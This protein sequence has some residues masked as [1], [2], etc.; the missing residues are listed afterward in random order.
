MDELT[1]ETAASTYF[2]YGELVI[3]LVYAQREEQSSI[4]PI[5]DLMI[6]ELYQH[7]R[8]RVMTYLKEVGVLG[9]SRNDLPVHLDLVL[10]T[11]LLVV[12]YV[13]AGEPRLALPVLQQ[14]EPYLLKNELQI[15]Y[16]F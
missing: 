2:K 3:T 12:G 13:P 10:F 15:T 14:D 11:L 5:H 1:H 6:P 4:P 9:L 16:H 7:I 8:V